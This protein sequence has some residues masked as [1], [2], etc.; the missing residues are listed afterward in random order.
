LFVH[1]KHKKPLKTQKNIKKFPPKPG[2]SSLVRNAPISPAELGAKVSKDQ[3]I[4]HEQYTLDWL[5]S[6]VFLVFL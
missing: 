2:F 4:T 3:K 1:I 5:Q 6:E